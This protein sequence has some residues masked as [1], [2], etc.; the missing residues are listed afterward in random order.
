MLEIVEGEV[1]SSQG[2]LG[3]M[4]VA[5]LPVCS[6]CWSTRVG[7]AGQKRSLLG[8]AAVWSTEVLERP[9]PR[10]LRPQDAGGRLPLYPS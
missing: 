9:G 2:A 7:R 1:N 6:E 4:G 3:L 10:E 8:A 5:R